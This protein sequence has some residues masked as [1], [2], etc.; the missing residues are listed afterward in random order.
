VTDPDLG[1]DLRQ[2]FAALDPVPDV[3]VAAGNAALE[4][5]NLDADLV[6]LT[7]EPELELSH[8]R[9]GQ[10]R[11]LAFRSGAAVVELELSSSG[12]GVRLLGQLEPPQPAE[13]TVQSAA[14]VRSTR[15]DSRGRFS[16]A[17]LPDEWMRVVVAFPALDGTREV[18]EWF[19]A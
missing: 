14:G 7:S 6:V 19:R 11:L 13:V 9:G 3:V 1:D 12:G 17:G 16:L 18:T 4:W 2:L 10:P 8:L 15:A 5:L